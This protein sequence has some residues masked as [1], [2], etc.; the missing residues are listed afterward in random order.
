VGIV[1]VLDHSIRC[2]ASCHAANFTT[3]TLKNG[4]RMGIPTQAQFSSIKR[5]IEK[6]PLISEEPMQMI[7][8]TKREKHKGHYVLVTRN[9]LG[10][11]VAKEK[12]QPFHKAED[13]T[14]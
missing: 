1:T 13:K 6:M 14:E 11:I 9:Q 4:V 10:Q 8:T 2:V 5:E 12:W 7:F 3:T